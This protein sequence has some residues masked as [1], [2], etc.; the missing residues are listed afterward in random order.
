[1]HSG[2]GADPPVVGTQDTIYPKPSFPLSGL[3]CTVR[4]RQ[5]HLV[6]LLIFAVLWSSLCHLR[7]APPEPRALL[8]GEPAATEIARARAMLKAW[9]NEAPEKAPRVL[10]LCY[11][12]PADRD[13][14]GQYRER[15]T[16]VL[17]HIRDFYSREMTAWG[18]PGRTIQLEFAQDGLLQ[19][20]EVK[21]VLKSGECSETD[22]S[23]G[24]AIRRDCLRVL[25]AAGVDGGFG[26]VEALIEADG[27]RIWG[28]KIIQPGEQ[29][30]FEISVH[31]VNTLTLRFLGKDG[32]RGAWSAWA[33][34]SL[35]RAAVGK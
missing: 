8:P 14:R 11:W 21:G 22:P 29:A 33:E 26:T 4:Q 24:Q 17:T 19:I 12:T 2:N 25:R 31:D 6:R 7:A 16:R 34:P 18:L 27:R 32:N 1:M 3:P 28:P 15:L 23:D 30:P 20:H 13:P 10:R 35:T 9:E 5:F